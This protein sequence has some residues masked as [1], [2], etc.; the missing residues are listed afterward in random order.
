MGK[1]F[2]DAG[3]RMS[4]VNTQKGSARYR[5]LG[6]RAP[7]RKSERIYKPRADLKRPWSAIRRATKLKGLRLQDLRH[8]FALTGAGSSLGLPIIGKL[9]GHARP[10]TTARYAFLAAD[11]MLRAA[12][13]IAEQIVAAMNKRPA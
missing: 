4:P 6:Q 9:L 7:E 8:S 13:T 12:E 3:N 2:D 11:P 5:Y 1:I 10:E